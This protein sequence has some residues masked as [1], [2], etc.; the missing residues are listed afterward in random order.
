MVSSLLLGDSKHFTGLLSAD[1]ENNFQEN[2]PQHVSTVCTIQSSENTR[3]LGFNEVLTPS[4]RRGLWDTHT[5]T[6]PGLP[7]PC[8]C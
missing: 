4:N 1:T 6:H 2:Y 3:K 7:M 8:V 5:H